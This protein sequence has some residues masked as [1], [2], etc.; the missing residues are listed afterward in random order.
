LL[1]TS[2]K[3]ELEIRQILDELEKGEADEE[4]RD[5]ERETTEWRR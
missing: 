3:A 5:G 2:L 1:R 4:W